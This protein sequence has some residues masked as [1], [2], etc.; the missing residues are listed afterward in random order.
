MGVDDGDGVGA[1]VYSDDGVG[2]C[3][4]FSA[5]VGIG[6]DRRAHVRAH[7]QVVNRVDLVQIARAQH[8]LHA[9][10]GDARVVEQPLA[11]RSC[12]RTHTRRTP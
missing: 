3:L 9:R 4:D 10:R 12:A 7:P 11:Q 5:S 8:R 1:D 2:V 6:V